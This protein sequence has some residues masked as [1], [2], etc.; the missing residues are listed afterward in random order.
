MLTKIALIDP[1]PYTTNYGLRCISSYLWEKGF[2][3]KMIFLNPEWGSD[4]TGKY[5]KAV[6]EDLAA[7][8]R[9]CD[10]IGIS[11]FTNFFFRAAEL[12]EFL[13][14]R[15]PEKTIVWG[16]IHA[17]VSPETA[18][19]HADVI[20]LG[21]GE[22]TA[23]ELLQMASQKKQRTDVL[24][25]WVKTKNGIIKNDARPLE[26][27]LDKYPYQ[28]YDASHM[29][30]IKDGR[31][32][33]VT[34]EMLK[35]ILHLGAHA[36]AYF[37]L[38][39]EENY[40]YLT[41]TSRG[42][43]FQCAYCCNN[44]YRRLYAGKGR[45]LRSRSIGHVMGEIEDFVKKHG[46]VNFISFFDDDF[47]ARPNEFFTEFFD[48]YDKRIHMPFKCNL[49]A[50]SVNREKFKRLYDSGL[51]NVEVGL[52][53]GSGR[54]HKEVYL[55]PFIPGKF[56]ESA[57]IM[58]EFPRVIKYYDVILDDPYED[59][60][61]MYETIKFLSSMPKPFHLS[62]FSLTFFPGTALYDRAVADGIVD[63]SNL[64]PISDKKNNKLY[65]NN[66]YSKILIL[67]AGKADP[68]FKFVFTVA[69][70]PFFL[71]LFSLPLF[72]SLFQKVLARVLRR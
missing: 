1:S 62:C 46:Y 57:R 54:V 53:S 8:V 50:F 51:T 44:A 29:H 64:K 17:T 20:C 39:T 5:S 59:E 27:N 61:D 22:E 2:E 42:C 70:L 23:L 38:D 13:K 35:E 67:A 18:I 25:T 40:Q 6:R 56:L 21:E 4:E 10:V 47:L 55:R 48:E 31:I 45:W 14:E 30:V 12:S 41:L 32:V 71:K 9:D 11:V 16:G 65:Y 49:G 7:L 36:K 28:D 52:Q 37:G 3:A 69:G 24:G 60:R 63:P 68:K 66:A 15:Y 58:A 19:Q 34:E 72:D 33:P 43:P 26:E